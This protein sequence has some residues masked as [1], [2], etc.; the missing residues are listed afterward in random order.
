MVSDSSGSGDR[1][2]GVYVLILVV[3]EYGL[4]PSKFEGSVYQQVIAFR[5][6]DDLPDLT[7]NCTSVS[8]C[9]ITKLYQYVKER[10]C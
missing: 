8:G 10:L 3:M 7:K 5:S 4:G 9:K 6:I 1:K 2:P